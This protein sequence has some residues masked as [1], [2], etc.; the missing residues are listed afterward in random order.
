LDVKN[1]V[2]V[3]SGGAQGIGEAVCEKLA[4][5]GAKVAVLDMNLAGADAVAA[6][7]NGEGL[8]AIGV[9]A[10]ITKNDQVEAAF[11]K[12]AEKLGPVDILVNNAGWTEGHPFMTENEAYWDKV[13]NINFKGTIYMC[14]AALKYMSEKK[15]GKIVNVGSDAARIGNA[16]EVVYSATKAAIITMSKSLAREVARYN[17]NVNAVCPGPTNTPLLKEQPEAMIEALKKAIPFR[18]VGEPSDVA[19]MIAFLCSKEASFVTGQVI[20]V[21]G[22]LTMVG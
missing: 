17:V 22:G 5:L 12:V 9:Q 15:F 7:L 4:R 14:K 19:N 21:S 11:Q 18:R 8:Q 2:A 20:S 6:R 13:I 3:V 16:G 1:L 10:D